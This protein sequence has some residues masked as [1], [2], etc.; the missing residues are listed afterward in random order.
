FRDY[1]STA[2]ENSALNSALQIEPGRVTVSPYQGC[3]SLCLAHT[4]AEIR[5]DAAGYRKFEYTL[6]QERGLDYLEDWFSPMTGVF[7]VDRNPRPAIIAS[8]EAR[9]AEDA[10]RYRLAEM[11]R[12]NAVSATFE[13]PFDQMLARAA[14]QFIVRRGSETTVIAGYHWFSDW[15]RDTMI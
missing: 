2:H 6:E 15:G 1:H 5:Q 12:R 3:P 9:A 4:D 8:T 13:E 7:D 10:D 11:A 14:D